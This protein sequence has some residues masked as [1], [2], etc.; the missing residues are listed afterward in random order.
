MSFSVFFSHSLS[1]TLSQALHLK[2]VLLLLLPLVLLVL[3]LLLLHLELL[4]GGISRSQN[5]LGKLKKKVKK[6]SHPPRGRVAPDVVL[7]VVDPGEQHDQ[8]RLGLVCLQGL[9]LCRDR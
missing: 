3:L 6:I 4:L 1:R 7:D 2:V 5:A 9:D 8:L